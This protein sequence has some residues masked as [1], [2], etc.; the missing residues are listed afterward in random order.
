MSAPPVPIIRGSRVTTNTCST[1]YSPVQAFWCYGGGIGF[2]GGSLTYA[3]ISS[4]LVADNQNLGAAAGGG[5]IGM[6]GGA[7][8]DQFDSNVVLNNV[9][10]GSGW[11]SYGGGICLYDT[12]PVSVTNNLLLDNLAD[13]PSGAPVRGG[14]IFADGP[15][16]YLA[17]NTVVSNTAATGGMGGGVYFDD[18]AL[19]STIVVGNT[20]GADGGGVFWVIGPGSAGYNDVWNNAPN[21]YAAGGSPAPGTDVNPPADPLFVGSGGVAARYHLR[22]AS[23]CVDHVPLAVP[24]VLSTTHDYDGDARPIH[25]Q[26]DVGFDEVWAYTFLPLALRDYP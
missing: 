7:T 18:G 14:G 23:P 15:G 21:D 20:A 24:G 5:G 12:N 8:A 16:F 3:V 13:D 17:Y 19:V 4:T 9:A 11:G 25:G 1:L 22:R 6:D 2:Y 26:Y 10:L